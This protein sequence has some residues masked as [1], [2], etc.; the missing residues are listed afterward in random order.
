[1]IPSYLT[2]SLPWNPLPGRGR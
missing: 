2:V 1:M